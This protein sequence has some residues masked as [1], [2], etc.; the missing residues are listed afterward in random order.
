MK[1]VYM[2]YLSLPEID[3]K[4]Y[5]GVLSD[6]IIKSIVSGNN[7]DVAL[8]AFTPCREFR[9]YFNKTRD[10]TK[11]KEVLH[12]MEDDEYEEFYDENKTI[13]IDYHGF[14]VKKIRDNIY[15]MDYESML[16]TEV[17]ADYILYY[18]EEYI[19]YY[20]SRILDDEYFEYIGKRK[21]KSKIW[22]VLVDIFLYEDIV[23]KI[24]PMEDVNID[25]VII[26]D[27]SLYIKLFSNT[28]SL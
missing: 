18:R 1:K 7:N 22:K 24:A 4:E 26:D 23:Y 21:F 6:Y 10:M 27:L 14:N 17:E 28:L 2:F 3:S 20:L 13:A 12:V 11:F 15:N 5:K 25:T 19:M 8:Y 16:C 9:D